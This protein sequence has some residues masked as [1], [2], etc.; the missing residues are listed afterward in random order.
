MFSR[1]GILYRA[2]NRRGRKVPNR[3]NL[4][5]RQASA[6][7]TGDTTTVRGVARGKG[8]PRQ[9]SENSN[10]RKCE[11]IGQGPRRGW[12][13][14]GVNVIRPRHTTSNTRQDSQR[15]KRGRTEARI[16]KR[17]KTPGTSSHTQAIGGSEQ[18]FSHLSWRRFSE[19]GRTIDRRRSP[20]ILIVRIFP[21][22]LVVLT[23]RFRRFA[24]EHRGAI[25]KA[26]IISIGS[27]VS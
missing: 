5:N 19:H 15:V 26:R 24:D 4:A 2:T 11:S 12:L 3:P 14:A 16:A 27:S 9:V 8:P 17:K 23:C 10:R 18:C 22:Q 1:L 21:S 13:A 20:L 25:V 6:Q 7:P